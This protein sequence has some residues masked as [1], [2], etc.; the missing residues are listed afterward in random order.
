MLYK[1]NYFV[2]LLFI[3]FGV[4][5]FLFSEQ[6]LFR[7]PDGD[8]FFVELPSNTSADRV[9][10][11]LEEVTGASK[12]TL[13]IVADGR[14]VNS[15][16]K[17]ST[18]NG[19]EFWVHFRSENYEEVMLIPKKTHIGYRKYQLPVSE[20]E[21]KDITFILKTLAQKSLASLWSY[22]SQLEYAG[23]RIDHLHPLRFLECIFTDNELKVYIY[24]IKKRGGWVWS[25]FIKGFKD[26]LQE[27]SDI[28]NLKDEFLKDFVKKIG[29]ELSLVYGVAQQQKWE[30]FVKTLII[31][32]P[33]EGDSGRYD[34]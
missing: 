26:S 20:S 23:D 27:E 24:N 31:N 33:R 32:V 18:Y 15:R 17:I 11:T 5:S 9:M 21:K 14:V 19:Q 25:E 4:S 29:V 1:K 16:E 22:K 12:E 34:Q 3:F 28:G 2:G 30:D 7:F 6:V 10:N 8:N 13:L